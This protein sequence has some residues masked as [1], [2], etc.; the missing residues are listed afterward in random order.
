MVTAAKASEGAGASVEWTGGS[1]RGPSERKVS[2]QAGAFATGRPA[3]LVK[4]ALYSPPLGHH[5]ASEAREGNM[6]WSDGFCEG[7]TRADTPLPIPLGQPR[8][9]DTHPPPLFPPFPHGSHPSPPI[10]L[11]PSAIRH[12]V[13]PV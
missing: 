12:P 7:H 1:G 11:P 2:L 8:G 10:R 13:A 9:V 5:G 4:R 3:R 6:H